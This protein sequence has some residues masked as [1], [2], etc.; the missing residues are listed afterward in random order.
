MPSGVKGQINQATGNIDTAL[1]NQETLKYIENVNKA[2]RALNCATIP[3]LEFYI[4]PCA[5]YALV[6]QSSAQEIEP[7]AT[8]TA[9]PTNAPVNLFR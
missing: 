9:P 3:I 6:L 1:E 8:A 4:E 5:I 2:S 7:I